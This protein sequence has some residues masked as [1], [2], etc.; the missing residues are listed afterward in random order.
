MPKRIREE[1]LQAIEEIV[2][3]HPEGPDYASRSARL[4][5]PRLRGEPYSTAS[6]PSLTVGAWSW[7][8]RD[9]GCATVC[10]D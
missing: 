3:L 9:A 2:R 8:V 4:W 6:S 5:R 7:R 10:R 1:H